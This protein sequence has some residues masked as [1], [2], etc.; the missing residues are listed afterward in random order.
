MRHAK[1]DWS[2]WRYSGG[3]GSDRE[4]PLSERGTRACKKIS[5]FFVA[6]KLRVDLIEYSPARRATDTFNLIK[7]SIGFTAHRQNLGLYT[8]DSQQLMR[9]ISD[10]PNEINNFLLIGHN[11]AI[12]NLVDDLVP[13]E[14]NSGYLMTL[15]KK[16]PTGAIAFIKLNISVWTDLRENCGVLLEFVRP[17]DISTLVG[18]Y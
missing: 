5:E 7:D 2:D 11:P 1:S 18:D 17:K 10:K 3:S 9:R 12:E 16:Y 4:R 13:H 15:R 14:Y 6:R 8:F